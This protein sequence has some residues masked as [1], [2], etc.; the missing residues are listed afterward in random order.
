MVG[1]VSAHA[2]WVHGVAWGL[3]GGCMGAIASTPHGAAQG[4]TASTPPTAHSPLIQDPVGADRWVLVIRV[5]TA[6][7]RLPTTL[8]PVVGGGGNDGGAA[9]PAVHTTG[10]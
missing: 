3:H 1:R 7:T 4:P 6:P 8:S 2:S 5:C 10:K 9:I